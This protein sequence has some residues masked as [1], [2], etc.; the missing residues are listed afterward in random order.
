MDFLDSGLRSTTLGARFGA[1][2]HIRHFR[3]PEAGEG[4]QTYNTSAWTVFT[5]IW[6]RGCSS[7]RCG[8][9]RWSSGWLTGTSGGRNPG[10]V[11]AHGSFVAVG[12]LGNNH[13]GSFTEGRHNVKQ[14]KSWT[15]WRWWLKGEDSYSTR[16]YE[17]GFEFA[18]RSCDL[19]C[20]RLQFVV[21]RDTA[22]SF[23]W[24]IRLR[25]DVVAEEGDQSVNTVT[26]TFGLTSR[27]RLLVL[28][29]RLFGCWLRILRLFGGLWW[30]V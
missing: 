12:C 21:L 25:I 24:T 28:R 29:L 19:R 3:I 7:C 22:T 26:G 15:T 5:W 9:C 13:R 27:R 20:G 18:Y 10:I 11:T 6:N 1:L 17:Y 2:E 14:A 23:I 30:T 16:I 4:Q 8:C